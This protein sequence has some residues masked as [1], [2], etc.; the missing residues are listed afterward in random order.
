MI[1]INKFP[2][3]EIR[4]TQLK[5]L[6]KINENIDKRY[7]ILSLGT[8]VGKSGIAKTICSSYDKS[9]I[10]TATKQLQDQYKT[11]FK[12]LMVIKGRANYRCFYNEKLNCEIGPCNINKDLRSECLQNSLC[13]YYNARKKA[14]A[15]P[16]VVSSYAYFLRAL[17]SS[18]FWKPRDIIIVDEC[19][20]LEQQL[21]QWAAISL[22]PEELSKKYDLFSSIEWQDFVG[23]CCAPEKIGFK[24]NKDWL[25]RV[26]NL[27]VR[28]R[29]ELFSNIE[30]KFE[31]KNPDD[32]SEEELDNI[33]TTHKDY[34]EIDKLYRKFSV[35]FNCKD[36]NDWLI[37]P[38]NN[39]LIITPLKLDD[40]FHRYIN[41]W[42]TKK[43]VF[44]SATILD[45]DGF[46]KDFGIPEDQTL[47]I[48]VDSEF[49]SQKSPIIYYPT[50]SMNYKNIEKTMPKI[51]DSVRDIMNK[52]PDEKGIIHTNTNLLAKYIY[53]NIDSDRLII[54]NEDENNE[55]I[56][57]RHI[58]SKNP[59]VLISPSLT[60]GIDL[61]NELSRFQI[62]IKMPFCNMTDKR[63]AQK[64][65]L[66]DTWLVKE[67]FLLFLQ[68]CG[69]STRNENDWSITY[70][71]DSSFYYWIS[72]YR[73]WFDQQFLKRIIW[74]KDSFN[75]DEFKK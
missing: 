33:S 13:P 18:N 6:N 70:I 37:E 54:K 17:D 52:F 5:T 27:V 69:R 32:L 47:I 7:C 50:G 36:K 45:I 28:K 1:N 29:L 68:A 4:D 24:E 2:Y 9:F 19:H 53:E 63:V 10:M 35:F 55:K 65:K 38:E 43:I 23:V 14:L 51:L 41:K 34:Y 74:K 59:T 58:S 42:A 39:G 30:D 12:E 15:T 21:V 60:T 57:K 11:E 44:M 40:I 8:G 3:P 31:G 22:S 49:Q 72:K 67:M 56:V 16:I 26:W 75:L 48:K 25:N 64:M 20:L 46:C 73:T 61:K 71:L 66:S 62:I